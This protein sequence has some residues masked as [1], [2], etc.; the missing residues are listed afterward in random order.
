M[1]VRSWEQV[2]LD[3]ARTLLFVSTVGASFFALIA[4]IG[5]VLHLGALSIVLGAM[6]AGAAAYL[7]SSAPRRIVGRVA[8]QQTLEAPAFAASSGI[9]L[10]STRSRNKTFLMLSAE[11][12]RLAS[13][14]IATKRRILTGYDAGAAVRD[15]GTD[16][17]IFSESVRSVLHSVASLERGR[18]ESGSDELDGMLSSMSL[19][20]ETK[21][22]LFMA[23]SFFLP[24]ML[25][26]FAAMTR[27]TGPVAVLA[28][29]VLEIVVLDIAL[30]ISRSSG[31]WTIRGES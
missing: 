15:E 20:D 25:M 31:G 9:Y 13:F 14:L 16:N 3:R 10:R 7:V 26:L 17:A 22:P 12:P 23:V 28:L 8:F 6:A 5:G 4:L 1:R 29:L 24:I 11:E 27:N 18:I 19:E 30:S 2:G 21:L